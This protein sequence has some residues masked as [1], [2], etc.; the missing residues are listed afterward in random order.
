MT[1][2]SSAQRFQLISIGPV[3][4]LSPSEVDFSSITAAKT[5]HRFRQPFLKSQFYSAL[6]G[7]QIVTDNVFST[8]DVVYHARHRRLLSGPMAKSNLKSVEPIVKSRIELAVQRMA[9]EMNSRGCA[10]VAKWWLF[11]AT[12]VIGELSFGDSFRML[13]IGKVSPTN[14]ICLVRDLDIFFQSSQYTDDLGRIAS[15]S[16]LRVS[17][18]ILVDIASILPFNIPMF[19]DAANSAKR[20]M[21]YS[22]ESLQRH[23]NIVK[24]DPNAKPT[25]FHKLYEAGKE[26]LS[27]REITADARAYIIAGSDT[28]ANSLTY[29]V[30]AV[31]KNAAIKQRL[32]EE[33]SKLS[34]DCSD[35]D[36]EKLPY[37][38]YVIQETLRMYAAA[39][40]ALPRHV[41]DEGCEIDDYWTPGGLTVTTQAWSMHRNR[42]VFTDPER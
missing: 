20:I 4:R 11:M 22:E 38:T 41:P 35:E 30:W 33:V 12:D 9:E 18:P 14:H 5:I 15:L 31:C 1:V 32:V 10:D 27:P 21:Q 25:L 2:K 42:S 16:G 13:E 28:T 36:L 7:K 17:F 3:V 34:K 39:P 24:A 37:L 8:R 6:V 40:G 29:L 23:R 26:G 19:R